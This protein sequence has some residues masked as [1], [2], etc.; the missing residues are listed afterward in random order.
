MTTKSV[1]AV[2]GAFLFPAYGVLAQQTTSA[3]PP[4]VPADI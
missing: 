2:L 4:D 1:L 3:E